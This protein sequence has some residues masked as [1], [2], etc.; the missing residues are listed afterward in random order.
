MYFKYIN[1][2]KNIFLTETH[3]SC[4][5]HII[6]MIN[7]NFMKFDN[8]FVENNRLIHINYLQVFKTY[9]FFFCVILLKIIFKKEKTEIK[10]D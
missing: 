2:M 7:M 9:F 8:L 3:I 5:L 6:N 10:F 4:K 1:F